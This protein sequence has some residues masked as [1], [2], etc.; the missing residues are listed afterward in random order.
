[1][2]RS[3]GRPTAAHA[4]R[5]RLEAGAAGCGAEVAQALAQAG[6]GSVRAL[7]VPDRAGQW[8]V[9]FHGRDAEHAREC[10][11]LLAARGRVLEE[12][13][14]TFELHEGGK[15]GVAPRAPLETLDQ[16]AMLYSPGVARVSAAIAANPELAWTHTIKRNT[17]AVVTDGTAV[18]GL[19]DI[20]PLAAEPVMS[21]KAL[22]FREF[23][24]VDA[25]P[26]CLDTR[27]PDEIV[28][29]VKAI[30][31]VFGGINLE[32]I[33]APRCFDIEARL[34]AELDIPV[35]HD[36]QHGTAIVVLA[37]LINA[38][39][40]T[41]R[42]LDRTRA[43]MLG[44]GA[45]GM[46]TAGIL[47][48]AGIGDVICFDRLGPVYAGR[49][50]LDRYKAE[51]AATSNRDRFR[52]TLGEALRGADVFIGLSGPGLVS[53]GDLAVMAPRAIVFALSNPEPEIRPEDLAGMD[54]AVVA[55][56]RSD[57]PNQINNVLAFPGVF[58]GALDSGAASIDEGM[59]IAAAHAIAGSVAD[60][61]VAAGMVVPGPLDRDVARRV[62]AAVATAAQASGAVRARG[63]ALAV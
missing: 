24:G 54:V 36:D 39:R 42:R 25:F 62:A 59:K 46:A 51:L 15:I 32:D 26:I 7:P 34:R 52:G 63:S 18:L 48:R 58:R 38:L 17:V 3:R 56:G 16:L 31:P 61:E 27:D 57:Y 43:V 28:A 11:R 47:T 23:A 22:L 50:G 35:F 49:P 9:S 30:A 4:F 55:T 13:D 44:A 10:L 40:F 12:V 45:A 29:A 8:S 1:M 19:G 14:V 6:A 20:G 53:A 41:D 5:V 33:S 21:G 2:S 37:G 60:A